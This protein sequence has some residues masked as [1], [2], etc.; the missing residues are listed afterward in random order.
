MIKYMIN[1]LMLIIP[2]F[3]ALMFVTFVAIRLVPGDPIEVR[4]GER[5]V[6]PARLEM[7]RHQMGLDLP[8]WRQFF[9]YASDILHGNFGISIISHEPVIKEFIK[10]F[11]ATIELSLAAMLFAIIIGI[12][13][14][15]MAAVKRGRIFDQI[16]MGITVTGYSMPIF[17]WGLLLI[18]LVAGYWGI[19]PVSGRIDLIAFDIHPVTGFMLIDS[20]LSDGWAAFV[21]ALRHLVLPMIVLG[22]I[23]LAMIARMTRSS[24]LEVLSDDYVRTAR[25]KGL[26]ESRVIGVHAMRNALIPVV[27]VIGLS[28]GSLLGGAVLTE[29]IFSW[30]GIGKW[31]ID[32]VNRRDYPAL[33]GAVM[34]IALLVMTVNFIVDALYAII[35]P[36]ILHD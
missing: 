2:T 31:V 30:P 4:A 28:V 7:L 6:S 29:T 32:S 19:L 12:P 26:R 13:A 35:Q 23:P 25:A 16:V 14:G 36:R 24:M 9:N 8:I 10:L 1:R 5:G 18:M 27:T 34:L 11:P 22:T 21:D 3:I 33:Q 20:L 17:W 15:I